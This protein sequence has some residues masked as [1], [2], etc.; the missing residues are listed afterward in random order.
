MRACP[1]VVLSGTEVPLMP[2]GPT[3]LRRRAPQMRIQRQTGNST[4]SSADTIRLLAVIPKNVT[5]HAGVPKSAWIDDDM[6]LS[7][8][9][10][11]FPRHGYLAMSD[12]A[13]AR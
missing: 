2:H 10:Q 13:W 12:R 7:Q 6:N 5:T 11:I 3:V 1:T 4:P 9:A 8:T